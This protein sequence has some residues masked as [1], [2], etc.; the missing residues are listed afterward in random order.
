M[1]VLKKD[2]VPENS[3]S[4]CRNLHLTSGK[5]Y[6]LRDTNGNIHYA[7]RN[8]AQQHADANTDFTQIPDLT[9]SLIANVAG[10]VGGNGGN[11]GVAN[12]ANNKPLAIAY[13]LLR[14]EKLQQYSFIQ[15]YAFRQLRT[16]Y[17]NYLQNNDLTEQEVD[18]V[19][20]YIQN[21]INIDQKLSLQNLETCY[22]YDYILGRAIANTANSTFLQGLLAHLHQHCTL[23][24]NQIQGLQNWLV[25]LPQMADC[26]LRNF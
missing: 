14:E 20:F 22:A 25:N 24:N 11:G 18:Q 1:V 17:D 7:G 16:I 5:A 6:Y 15:R 2:F 26:H 3:I 13:L 23:S 12:L 19:M 8:C 10:H 9:K 4:Y 21:S